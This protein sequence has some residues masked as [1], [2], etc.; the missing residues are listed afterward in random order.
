MCSMSSKSRTSVHHLPNTLA[1]IDLH[2]SASSQFNSSLSVRPFSKSVPSLPN[3][4][5]LYLTADLFHLL[6]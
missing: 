2:F 1:A 6:S 5:L 4:V 3:E